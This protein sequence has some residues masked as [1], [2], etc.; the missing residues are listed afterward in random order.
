[1]LQRFLSGL[2]HSLSGDLTIH[3][4]VVGMGKAAKSVCEGLNGRYSHHCLHSIYWAGHDTEYDAVSCTASTLIQSSP[5]CFSAEAFGC[6]LRGI[7]STAWYPHTLSTGQMPDAK[8][9]LGIN[10]VKEGVRC[11]EGGCSF[12]QGDAWH[13]AAE[14][15]KLELILNI[16]TLGYSVVYVDVDTVFFR[17][18]M[19]HLLSLKVTPSS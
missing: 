16:V 14:L 9:M 4:V 12:S 2:K 5:C 11:R 1:M 3:A 8:S 6:S 15:H 10:G 17:N 7:W 13:L 19:I 18:P